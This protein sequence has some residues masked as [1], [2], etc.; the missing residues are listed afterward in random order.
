MR[1]TAGPLAGVATTRAVAGPQPVGIVMNGVDELPGRPSS[2]R[3][4]D[5]IVIS[6]GM[7][8]T[9]T[10][11]GMPLMTESR[12]PSAGRRATRVIRNTLPAA[13]GRTTTP[14]RAGSPP[15]ARL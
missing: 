2:V 1:V 10:V 3:F 13:G 6:C 9:V 14:S 5:V 11:D 15:G 7:P 12:P 8:S 4:I